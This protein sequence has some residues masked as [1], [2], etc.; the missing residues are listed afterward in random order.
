MTHSRDEVSIAHSRF[1]T[2]E[3]DSIEAL[4]FREKYV[5]AESPAASSGTTEIVLALADSV[6]TAT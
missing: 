5:N 3:L 1:H 2:A 6:D 4:G